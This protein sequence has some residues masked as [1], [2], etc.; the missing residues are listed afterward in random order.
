MLPWSVIPLASLST[1]LVLGVGLVHAQGT[2]NDDPA[3]FSLG[4]DHFI[5][6][7]ADLVGV[8]ASLL[9]DHLFAE[10]WWYRL[11]GDPAETFLPVP[12]EESYEGAVATLT[13]TDVNGRG[14]DA[15][16]PDTIVHAGGPSGRVTLSL[17]VTNPSGTEPLRIAVFHLADIDLA[18]SAN[19][20]AVAVAEGLIR[21]TDGADTAEY[22]ASGSTRFL[23]TPSGENDVAGALFDGDLDDFGDTGLPFCAGDVTAGFQ[24]ETTEIPPNGSETFTVVIAVNTAAV[25]GS[26][27]TTTTSSTVFGAPTTSTTN[28]CGGPTS[29]TIPG[30]GTTSTTIPGPGSTEACDNCRDDDGD[31][32]VDFEDPDCCPAAT[33]GAIGLSRGK[34]KGTGAAGAASV[35]LAGTLPLD[36]LPTTPG[37]AALTL[38]IARP[39][40]SNLLCARIPAGTFRQ[41]KGKL[42]FRDPI[43]ALD[44]VTITRGKTSGKLVIRGKTVPLEVPAPGPLTVTFGLRDPAS[45]AGRCAIG[46]GNFQPKKKGLTLR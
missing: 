15:V 39:G 8:S 19:D 6:A 45:P 3:A 5:D 2:I 36:V 31:A 37:T 10:G 13:W 41:R 20:S 23:V 14:F 40:D 26:T 32:L 17:N 7:S 11:E 1:V 21:V 9:D 4:P 42:V 27:P 29:T 12:D 44:R 46:S 33:R 34:L 43:E 18:G 16:E 22:F 25:P 30:G 35:V 24:W 38:Q 28:A